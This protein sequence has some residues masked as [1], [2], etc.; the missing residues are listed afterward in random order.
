MSSLLRCTRT[1]GGVEGTDL[2]AP[3]ARTTG[4]R[5]AES[6][7]PLARPRLHDRAGTSGATAAR[8]VLFPRSAAPGVRVPAWHPW[9]SRPQHWRG[10]SLTRSGGLAALGAQR[11]PTDAG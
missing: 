10:P 8:H 2:P 4:L 6:N 11:A 7:V 3:Q 5:P 9:R 1:T